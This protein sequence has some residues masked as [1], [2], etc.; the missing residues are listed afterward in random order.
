MEGDSERSIALGK[1]FGSPVDRLL[2]AAIDGAADTEIGDPE[3][4]VDNNGSVGITVN[5]SV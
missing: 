1:A 4:A 5:I 2:G 3:G